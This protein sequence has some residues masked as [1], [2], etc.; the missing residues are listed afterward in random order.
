ML[1]ICTPN[2]VNYSLIKLLHVLHKSGEKWQ[3][4]NDTRN[5]KKSTGR[6]ICL[7]NVFGDLVTE[8]SKIANLLNYRFS[9]LSDYF[10]KH[11]DLSYVSIP[12][13]TQS[14]SFR[15][16]TTRETL[17]LMNF[18]NVR[19]STGPSDLPPWTLKVCSAEIA[20]HLFC[21]MPFKLSFSIQTCHCNTDIQ[22]RRQ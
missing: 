21:S 17:K 2:F 12:K 8:R 1:G 15:F 20:E 19:K 6:I 9:K 5:P 22:E 16:I 11:C 18:L 10:G 3:I 4:I 14:F 13:T 7:R